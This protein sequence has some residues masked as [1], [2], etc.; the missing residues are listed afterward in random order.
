MARWPVHELDCF[1]LNLILASAFDELCRGDDV[2]HNDRPLRAATFGE[3]A[4]MR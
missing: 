2:V 3:E 4:A 1:T